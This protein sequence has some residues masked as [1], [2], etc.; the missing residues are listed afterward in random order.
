MPNVNREVLL[1]IK[2]GVDHLR[3]NGVTVQEAPPIKFY[4]LLE[5]TFSTMFSFREMPRFMKRYD[6]TKEEDDLWPEVVN[7][8]FGKSKYS[9]GV[10]IFSLIKRL[11]GFMSRSHFPDNIKKAERIKKQ[12]IVNY[13]IFLYLI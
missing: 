2:R 13:F 1:S 6:N 11:D 3:T 12:I 7:W 10:I 5:A 4:H 8:L 9:A